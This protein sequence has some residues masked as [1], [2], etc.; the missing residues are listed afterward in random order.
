MYIVIKMM[1]W[2]NWHDQRNIIIVF[3]NFSGIN[4]FVEILSLNLVSFIIYV[5]PFIK[6]VR[7]K[8][9]FDSFIFFQTVIFIL[10][11]VSIY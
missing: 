4:M 5:I 2:N 9:P 10:K 3:K 7:F 11:N 1:R 6:H 8:R